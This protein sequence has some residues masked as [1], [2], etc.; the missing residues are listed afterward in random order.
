MSNHYHLLVETPE[1]G[2]SRGVKWLN[3]R[4]AETFNKRHER[5]GHLFQGRFKSILVER[6]RHLLEL[7]RYVVLNP[8]RCGM[9]AFAGEYAWSNYRATA[10]LQL[11]P[12]WVEVGWTLDQFGGR[13]RAEAR[14]AYRRWVADGRGAAYNPREAMVGQM[15]LGGEGFRERM[16]Q[17]VNVKPRSSEHPVAQRTPDRPPMDAIAILVGETF[18]EAAGMLRRKSR[19]DARKAIALVAIDDARLTIR[20]IANWLQVTDWAVEKMRRAGCARYAADPQFRLRVDRV[21]AALS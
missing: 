16:Q 17:L 12:R 14:E 11:P 15:Y 20:C 13:D 19:S 2:L 21:R 6:E 10:G 5:V 3:Q 4:Y 7:L 1:V 18:G 9:V 8:V